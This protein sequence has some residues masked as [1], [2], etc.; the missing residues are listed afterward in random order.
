VLQA[1]LRAIK[2]GAAP[3]GYDI[4]S[5]RDVETWLLRPIEMQKTYLTLHRFRFPRM[6]GR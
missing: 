4:A 5:W 3:I 2:T 6:G 1:H